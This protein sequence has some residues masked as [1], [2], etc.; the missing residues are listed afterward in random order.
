MIR[1]ILAACVVLTMAAGAVSCTPS[2]TPSGTVAAV[3]TEKLLEISRAYLKEHHPDWVQE[4]YDLPSKIT[5][6]GAYWEVRFEL[7]ANMVGGTPVIQVAKDGL[8]VLKA[9][10]EQ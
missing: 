4:T 7:P 3:P 6:E 1:S 8:V 10:H 9:F 2:A 5:D